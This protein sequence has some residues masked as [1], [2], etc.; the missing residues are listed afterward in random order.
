MLLFIVME[1]CQEGAAGDALSGRVT[2]I[3]L[4]GEKKSFLNNPKN[5]LAALLLSAG[6]HGYHLCGQPC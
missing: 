3:L 2:I 1:K 6:Y 4:R 5:E